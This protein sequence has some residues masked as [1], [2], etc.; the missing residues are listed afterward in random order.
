MLRDVLLFVSLFFPFSFQ[1]VILKVSFFPTP[2]LKN[3]ICVCQPELH[4]GV[5][6]VH[7]ALFV[8]FL[9]AAFLSP[10]AWVCF[11]SYGMLFGPSLCLSSPAGGGCHMLLLLN[12]F[13]L[14]EFCY[15]T[16]Q[17]AF[18]DKAKVLSL[19]FFFAISVVLTVRHLESESQKLL[20]IYLPISDSLNAA[21]W[22]ANLLN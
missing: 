14:R 13:C 2:F 20:F 7:T 19:F 4:P 22:A 9:C 11:H 10:L 3:A 6:N 21:T 17:V 18:S 15:S 12:L 16:K 5:I 1:Q 8:T